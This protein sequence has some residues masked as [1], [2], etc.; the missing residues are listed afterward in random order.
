MSQHRITLLEGKSVGK[1]ADVAAFL[2]HAVIAEAGKMG[3]TNTIK[4]VAGVTVTRLSLILHVD[5][6]DQGLTPEQIA[7]DLGMFK[8]H[9]ETVALAAYFKTRG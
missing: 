9:F 4:G 5:V 6:R 7:H 8:A 1:E 2:V 3:H